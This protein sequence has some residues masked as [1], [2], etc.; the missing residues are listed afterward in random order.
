MTIGFPWGRRARAARRMIKLD[1]VRFCA[2]LE[3]S[4]FEHYHAVCGRP[5]RVVVA[6]G[7]LAE[8][9]TRAAHLYFADAKSVV[10]DGEAS[11]AD[12]PALIVRVEALAKG[13]FRF[14]V[15]G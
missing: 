2:R 9:A 6:T 12:V 10:T 4:G 11:S 3:L 15:A 8:I 14:V 1:D 5:Y 13:R 7:D